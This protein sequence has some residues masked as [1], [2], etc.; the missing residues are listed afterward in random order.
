MRQAAG[1]TPRRSCSWLQADCRTRRGLL[2]I[3]L[4][5]FWFVISERLDGRRHGPRAILRERFAR[6]DYIVLVL[7]DGSAGPAIVRG[8]PVVVSAAIIAVTLRRGIFRGRQIAAA[9]LSVRPPVPVAATTATAS[10]PSKTP[11][12]STAS[13]IPV[14]AAISTAVVSLRPIVADARRIVSGRV[15]AGR[16]ILGRGGV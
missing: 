5:L 1:E 13:A 2:K 10:T 12:A 14:A 16:E 6:Q 8:T 15:V 3:G 7:L 4:T 9:A 11:A